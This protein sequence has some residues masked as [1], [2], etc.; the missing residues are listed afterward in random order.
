M[1]FI[2]YAVG[3]FVFAGI[4]SLIAGS[5]GNYLTQSVNAQTLG[6][7]IGNSIGGALDQAGEA[8]GNAS[9]TLGEVGSN[10]TEGASQAANNTASEVGQAAN[11]ATS[12]N[13]TNA[14]QS[15]NPLE[16][17]MNLFKGNK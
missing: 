12:G 4:I 17:L 9:K 16:M 5:G 8:A 13:G 10:A 15:K 14:T 1:N 7:K 11:N 2:K 6:E 3:I